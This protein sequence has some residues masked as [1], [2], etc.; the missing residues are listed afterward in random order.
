MSVGAVATGLAL[1]TALAPTGAARDGSSSALPAATA[2]EA[3]VASAWPGGSS[4]TLVDRTAYFGTDVSGLDLKV[5]EDP[6]DDVLWAVDDQAGLLL[7][8][9]QEHGV[10]V[11]D[12]ANGWA[13]GKKVLFADGR[14]PDVEGVVVVNGWAYLSTERDSTGVS[15]ASVLRVPTSGTATTLTASDEWRLN[16]DF[17]GIGANMGFE[18][19]S[20]VPDDFLTEGRFRD[21]RTGKRYDPA[22]YPDRVGGGL[23]LVAAETR[24]EQGRSHA[25]ALN[26]DGSFQRVATIAN[27][28]LMVMDLAFDR[29]TGTLWMACD[30]ECAGQVAVARLTSNRDGT[31]SFTVT[32]VHSRPT[33]LPDHNN[34]GFTVAPTSRCASGM[35][36]VF[37]SN[38]SNTG[39]HV[40]RR[41]TVRCTGEDPFPAPLPEPTPTTTPTTT[42]T[43]TPTS[44]PVAPAK[45]NARV[46]A[47]AAWVRAGSVPAV[48]VV[49]TA[50][51]VV[52]DGDVEVEVGTR[53]AT[54][55]LVDGRVTVRLPAFPTVGTR[56]VRVAYLGDAETHAA[57]TTTSLVVGKAAT[58]LTA[59][60]KVARVAPGKRARLAMRLRSDVATPGKFRVTVNGKK[61]TAR[62]TRSGTKVVVRT[63]VLRRK[64]TRTVA[65][66]YLGS[67][68]TRAS[69][70]KFKVKVR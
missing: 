47:S 50:G 30:D 69:A 40:L 20:F 55:S 54:G 24:G 60:T 65:V 49:V 18:S 11:R 66:R 32:A 33:G 5:A 22:T 44:K 29:S 53:R 15:R 62:V 52:P 39:S 9:V 17:P 26:R 23:F 64:G 63:P 34:E 21:D 13:E 38:D 25:Y 6:V 7:R 41:G 31:T 48:E 16:P 1:A 37:W 36:P 46:Q 68:S 59:T 56:T 67:G 4:T 28:L 45:A 42:P 43:V 57:N 8:L 2:Q 35:R 14:L 12:S 3:L 70:L 10:W 58:R 51:S 27:P 61:V 19:I